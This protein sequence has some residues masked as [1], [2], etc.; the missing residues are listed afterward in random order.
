ML[1]YHTGYQE[2]REPDIHFGRKNADFGQ[3]FYLTRDGGFAGRWAKERK[4]ADIFVNSY[5]L[6]L[7]GLQVM[8]FVRDEAWYDY[9]YHNRA[10][11]AD[12][13]PEADVILGPIA[14]DTIYNTFGILTSGFLSREQSLR[15]LRLGALYEQIVL[16][17]EKAASQL[18]WLSSR[19]LEPA[20]I[21]RYRELVRAE[22]EE[23]QKLFSE[24]MEGM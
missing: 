17:T 11:A 21:A 20:E 24:A 23:Y 2:I 5:E 4:G 3:G 6:S 8:R 7:E 14:N 9:I 1:V 12:R 19:I 16:K 10:G 22:E 13:F 18:H 15:L